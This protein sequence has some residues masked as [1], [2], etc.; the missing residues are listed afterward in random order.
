MVGDV[1]WTREVSTLHRQP[2][3][4]QDEVFDQAMARYRIVRAAMDQTGLGEKPVE[5]AQLRHGALRVEGV[6]FTQ[7]TKLD[8][9]T[10]LKERFEDR[11]IRI[12]S[13]DPVL[14]SDLHSVRKVAGVG[15]NVR[16]LADETIDG[17]ADRF[18]AA[19]LMAG[20]ASDGRPE[21][22]Y[23]PGHG[24]TAHRP[25]D[26]YAVMGQARFGRGTW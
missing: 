13:G 11:K 24:P 1:A 26:R 4:V 21:Y 2:F 23:T 3:R 20:A 25:V 16:L 18:W 14:R 9:A 12:P 17:H 10:A 19:A 15:G 22:A 6:K 5:D 8:M 7:A